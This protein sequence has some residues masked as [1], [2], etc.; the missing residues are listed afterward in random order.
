M[1]QQLDRALLGAFNCALSF[2]NY[3]YYDRAGIFYPI[4]LER[5]RSVDFAFGWVA[6]AKT[7]AMQR[8][9][10]FGRYRRGL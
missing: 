3:K 9:E 8:E 7:T 1:R 2:D 4:D 6:R 5:R 10:Y